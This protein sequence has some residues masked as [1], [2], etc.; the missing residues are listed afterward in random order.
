MKKNSLFLYF[1]M[2]L[3]ILIFG[4]SKGCSQNQYKWD[5]VSITGFDKKLEVVLNFTNSS[6][7][8]SNTGYSM[9]TIKRQVHYINGQLTISQIFSNSVHTIWNDTYDV[10]LLP[11]FESDNSIYW[12]CERWQDIIFRYDRSQ[13]I[14]LINNVT[15]KK[16][17]TLYNEKN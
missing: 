11:Y 13:H 15:L 10:E 9:D 2:I 17:Q 4:A 8:Y 12:R 1:A 7:H 5:S 3:I 14:F 6:I 16:R